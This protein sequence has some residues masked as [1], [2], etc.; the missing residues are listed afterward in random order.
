MIGFN[1]EVPIGQ[2]GWFGMDSELRW[3]CVVNSFINVV[4]PPIL[5]YGGTVW[6]NPSCYVADSED[7]TPGTYCANY[8]SC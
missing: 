6:N 1:G 3:V 7:G 5:Y 8:F 2:G 4:R